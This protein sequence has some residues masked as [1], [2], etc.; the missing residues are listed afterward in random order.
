MPNDLHHQ[1]IPNSKQTIARS[2]GELARRY[3][4]FVIGL[5]ISA[6]GVALVTKADLGTSPISSIPLVM[7]LFTPLSLGTHTILMSLVLIS[8]QLLILGRRFPKAYWLQIPVSLCFGFFIDAAMYLLAWVAP[9]TYPLQAVSL[10]LGCLVLGI[11]VYFELIA[12]VVMLPG[13]SFVNALHLRWG[14]DFG[15]TK[16]AFDSSMTLIAALLS[17]IVFGSLKGVREGTIVAALVVGWIARI[18]KHRLA[19]LE[20]LLFGKQTALVT[21]EAGVTDSVAYGSGRIGPMDRPVITIS[22]EFGTNGRRLAHRIAQ[23]LGLDL[24]DRDIV[25]EAAKILGLSP[26]K[27]EAEDQKLLSALLFDW[28]AQFYAFSD[29]EPEQDRLFEEESRL[30][31]HFAQEGGCVILGRCSNVLCADV[32]PLRL[33]LY[34]DEAHKVA[35]VAEREQIPLALAQ[36]KVRDYNR[37]R[38]RHYKYYTGKEWRDA[39]NYDLCINVALYDEDEIVEMVRKGLKKRAA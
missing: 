1:H 30:V 23:D 20:A 18:L 35:C 39:H 29:Q 34:A 37:E 26:S 3:G 8:L 33:F 28:K 27:T 21:N 31:R 5:M 38:G 22:R 32:E 2:P 36:H 24:H 14:F 4:I 11:G 15:K 13:E 25:L 12:D 16:I 19:A 7:S 9:Q 10:I 17:V 6:L